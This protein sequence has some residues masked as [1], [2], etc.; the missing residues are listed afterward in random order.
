MAFAPLM[1]AQTA[2]DSCEPSA[3]VRAALERLDIPGDIRSSGAERAATRQSIL[4]GLFVQHPEDFFVHRRYQT[5]AAQ[6]WDFDPDAL[7]QRYKELLEKH[8][9]S[10]QF[11]DLYG[12]ALNG[13]RT[14][15]AIGYFEKALQVDPNFGWPH[16]ELARVYTRRA[17]SDQA[18]LVSNLQAFVRACPETLEPYQYI[19]TLDDMTFLGDSAVRLRQILGRRSD[20]EALGSYSLLWGLEFRVH[21]AAENGALKKQVAADVARIRSLQFTQSENWYA[22]L[23]DG[24]ELLGDA[25]GEKAVEEQAANSFANSR[26]PVAAEIGH[27]QAEH[28]WPNDST[29]PDKKMV[30]FLAL[31]LVSQD[32]LRRWPD[33]PDVWMFRFQ[34]MVNLPDSSTTDIEAAAEGL[35]RSV[36][37]NPDL[38]HN[39]PPISLTVAREYAEKGIRIEDVPGLV[40]EGLAESDRGDKRFAERD[41]VVEETRQMLKV[42]SIYIH[43][44]ACTTLATAYVKMKD[45][46]KA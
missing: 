38:F 12:L 17:F 9:D 35:L 6:A 42:S 13:F 46:G 41:A 27:W 44:E 5:I 15:E 16:V 30:S 10:P 36:A 2:P 24:Y 33:Y 32:W 28:P 7:I 39:S 29:P 23:S 31:S 26:E 45:P 3:A 18:K 19:K 14:K 22:A 21:P 40:S 8:P 25:A 37:R 1:K 11:L 43:G 4:D 20:S 34:A